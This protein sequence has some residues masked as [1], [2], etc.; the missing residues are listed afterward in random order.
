[1]VIRR[2]GLCFVVLIAATIGGIWAKSISDKDVA[3]RAFVLGKSPFIAKGKWKLVYSSVHNADGFTFWN[4]V[5]WTESKPE[6]VRGLAF[7]AEIP[8]PDFVD[9]VSDY[10]PEL[11]VSSAA[12]CVHIKSGHM[13]IVQV[14]TDAGWYSRF[15]SY[16]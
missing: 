9:L 6:V 14:R 12:D 4:G 8:S 10:C 13:N 1:M 5:I 15:W 16:K 7:D 11:D 3:D 2:V